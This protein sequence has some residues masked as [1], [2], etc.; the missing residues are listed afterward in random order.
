MGGSGIGGYGMGGYG[1]DVDF[2]MDG[3]MYGSEPIFPYFCMDNCLYINPDKGL[4]LYCFKHTMQDN[5][6]TQCQKPDD[7]DDDFSMGGYGSMGGFGS[8]GD[9]GSMGGSMMGG[10]GSMMGGSGSMMGG[11]GSMM[12][13]SGS[14]MGGSGSM[15]DGY[16]SMMGGSGSMMGGSGSMMGGSSSMMSGSGSMMSGS[17]MEGQG[18]GAASGSTSGAP[19]GAASGSAS[20]APSGAASV[21]PSGASS[22]SG[23]GAS[24]A[25][26]GG[27]KCGIKKTSRIVGGAET[28]INEYPWMASIADSQES[29]FCGGTLIAS[30]WVLTA[31]HCMFKD[32]A[33]T[34][35]QTA[36]EL[37]VVLGEH[38]LLTEGEAS[39]IPKKA[40]KVSKI[41]NHKDYNSPS[42]TNNDITLLQLAEEV[43]MN[44]YTPA[45]LP[46]T[47]DNFE[48]KNAWVYGW[49]TTDYGGASSNKLL[50]VEV[51]VVSNTVCAAAMPEF[52][53][54]DSMLCAG[55][56]AG[57]DGCQGDSGGPLTVDVDGKHVLIGDVS[58]GNKCGLAGKYGV[59]GDVAFFKTW[60]DTNVGENG[61]AT[62]CPA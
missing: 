52:T 43:D 24:T 37:L 35:P 7:F 34:Q 27:C 6:A 47:A 36:G 59:Y 40:V 3:G 50:E 42:S 30:Q 49:G 48:G 18:S 60:I 57:K 8:M 5:Y 45:C 41:I 61:G 21:T 44:V 12:G 20:G 13:G 2:D 53:I 4:E 29:Q 33:G 19:S 54:T 56:V 38:D 32:Q 10:Y 14:M 1:N 15:M 25:S 58:F 62:Y 55:G 17:M 31:A 11:S 46:S 22:G 51:P 9:F 26:S 28:E 23:S 16:G 39:K